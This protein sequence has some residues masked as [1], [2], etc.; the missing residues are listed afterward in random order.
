MEAVQTR[1]RGTGDQPNLNQGRFAFSFCVIGPLPKLSHH[2]ICKSSCLTHTHTQRKPIH[3]SCMQDFLVWSPWGKLRV[4][5]KFLSFIFIYVLNAAPRHPVYWLLHPEWWPAGLEPELW[6]RRCTASVLLQ[7]DPH[8]L[9][10]L[11]GQTTQ[12]KVTVEN[13]HL[14][15]V[16]PS[17]LYS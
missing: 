1:L 14:L 7:D 2:Q 11:R 17:Q 8:L 15:Q 12:T 4:V 13:M 5:W 16:F 6:S 10:H 3:A 9:L